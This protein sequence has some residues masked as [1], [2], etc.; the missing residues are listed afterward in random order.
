MSYKGARNELSSFSELELKVKIEWRD[1]FSSE[2]WRE[3][4]WILKKTV[5]LRKEVKVADTVN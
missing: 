3:S 5:E 2:E 4:Y 1:V